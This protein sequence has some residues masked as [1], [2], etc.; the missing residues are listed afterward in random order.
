MKLCIEVE[1]ILNEAS[2]VGAENASF[3][4]RQ[5][6]LV[7]ANSGILAQSNAD[8]NNL[9]QLIVVSKRVSR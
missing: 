3:M 5:L 8:T 1:L 9:E 2:E 4:S 6:W 7:V